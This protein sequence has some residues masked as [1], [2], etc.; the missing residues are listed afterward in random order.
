[1]PTLH[2]HLVT[3]REDPAASPEL[4]MNSEE[5]SLTVQPRSGITKT[6]LSEPIKVRSVVEKAA[7]KMMMMMI[8]NMTAPDQCPTLS[9]TKSVT[10][11]V[12]TTHTVCPCIVSKR[13]D[14]PSNCLRFGSSVILVLLHSRCYC[15]LRQKLLII[16]D[17]K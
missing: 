16:G 14:M 3:G 10:I 12:M 7:S 17:I 11:V 2:Q 15:K 5:Q 6:A 1:M 8:S 4:A 13:L 9:V